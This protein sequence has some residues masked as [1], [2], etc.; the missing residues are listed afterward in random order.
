MIR[1][2]CLSLLAGAK[3]VGFRLGKADVLIVRKGRWLK[4]SA[5]I[6]LP[7]R[8]LTRVSK[9]L[10][11]WQAVLQWLAADEIQDGDTVSVSDRTGES[12]VSVSELGGAADR[13]TRLVR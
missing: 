11:T 9:G 7:E 1:D 2:G 4:V 6:L 10:S 13:L 5:C 8:L 3:E 12:T